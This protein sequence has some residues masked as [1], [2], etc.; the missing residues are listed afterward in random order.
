[1]VLEPPDSHFFLA[2]SGWLDLGNPAEARLELERISHEQRENPDVLELDWAIHVA[3]KNWSPALKAAEKIV[4]T[5]PER[6]SGWLHLA[7]AQRRAEG[8]GLETAWNT[9]LPAS[10]KFPKEPVIPFN[11]AC[12]A[13]QLGNLDDARQW[14]DR[15]MAIGGKQAITKMALNDPDLEPL[16]VELRK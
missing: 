12:Y 5:A 4:K 11:L 14:L 7:Y 8:G 3:E 6:P 16:W 13:C 1:M 10:V 2:A 15:A 9:L